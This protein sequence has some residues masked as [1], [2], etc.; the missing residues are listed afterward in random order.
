M[1]HIAPQRD[2]Q[3]FSQGLEGHEVSQGIKSVGNAL[4]NSINTGI[5]VVQ[6]ANETKMM[7]NQIDL[8]TKFLAK[9][10]KSILSGK[11]IRQI[12][13]QKKKDR[14]PLKH[15]QVSTKSIL[16]VKHNGMK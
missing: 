5:S 10:R 15:L 1:V 6:K 3:Y 14:K 8:S 2:R 11:L 4:S 7:N 12:L 13:K 9:T 16:C